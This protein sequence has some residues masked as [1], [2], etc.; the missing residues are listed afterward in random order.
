MGFIPQRP[1]FEPRSC[2]FCIGQ[3]CGCSVNSLVCRTVLIPET[4]TYILEQS[5][6]VF[7][8]YLQDFA[9]SASCNMT[10]GLK[11][12]AASSLPDTHTKGAIDEQNPLLLSFANEP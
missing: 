1:G 5:C 2:R 9:V 3:P 7:P 12:K 11:Q 8:R 10:L 6:L 4:A